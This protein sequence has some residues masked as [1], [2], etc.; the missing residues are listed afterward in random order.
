MPQQ[1]RELT[2]WEVVLKTV[3]EALLRNLPKIIREGYRQGGTTVPPYN[4]IEL[5]ELRNFDTGQQLS[6]C[7]FMCDEVG[8][9]LMSFSGVRL[10]GLDT[11]GASGEITFPVQDVKLSVP[12]IVKEIVVAGKWQS[13]SR[14]MCDEETSTTLHNGGFRIRFAD[15]QIRLDVLLNQAATEVSAADITL[16][17]S[18]NTWK[19]QP[20]F[21]PSE[22]LTFES[23]VPPGGKVVLRSLMTTEMF[24]SKLRN[25]VK[26]LIESDVLS[27]QIRSIANSMLSQIL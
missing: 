21:A 5:P 2:P 3:V 24:K 20:L 18:N 9:S 6:L 12:M 10:N 22:D 4:N 1:N 8:T 23:D 13:S 17:D 19:D 26:D 27:G 11:I 14:C 16:T 7:D 15:V 25:P